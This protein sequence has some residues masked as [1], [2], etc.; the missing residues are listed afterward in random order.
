MTWCSY[1]TT[2]IFHKNPSWPWSTSWSVRVVYSNHTISDPGIRHCWN[3]PLLK[4]HHTESAECALGFFWELSAGNSEQPEVGVLSAQTFSWLDFFD[5]RLTPGCLTPKKCRNFHVLL[6][7]CDL[8]IHCCV[9]FV[10]KAKPLGAWDPCYPNKEKRSCLE[11]SSLIRSWDHEPL[12]K[13]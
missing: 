7:S 10:G 4:I 12:W 11:Q 13:K 6:F 2:F 8:E 5:W 1:H 3:L 9:R